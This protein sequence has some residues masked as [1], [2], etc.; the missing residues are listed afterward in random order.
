M[1][2]RKHA[3]KQLNFGTHFS[4]TH[5]LAFGLFLRQ[6]DTQGTQEMQK[7]FTLSNS[8]F[9]TFGAGGRRKFPHFFHIK[10]GQDFY[11][12]LLKVL[13]INRSIS[14]TDQRMPCRDLLTRWYH[15]KSTISK[16]SF[17][18]EK[19]NVPPKYHPK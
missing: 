8:T 3:R 9:V 19:K 2:G 13:N 15:L 18:L 11:P 6:R 5:F 4:R 16:F 7:I 17:P 10:R 1:G 12:N 14:E